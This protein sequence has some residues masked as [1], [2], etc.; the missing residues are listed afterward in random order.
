[1]DLIDACMISEDIA[2]FI[3][4]LRAWAGVE[5]PEQQDKLLAQADLFVAAS[6]SMAA[7]RGCL[8]VGIELLDSMSTV[9]A[10]RIIPGQAPCGFHLPL[11][12]AEVSA[13]ECVLQQLACQSSLG[14]EMTSSILSFTYDGKAHSLELS[15]LPDRCAPE[16]Y[17][18][19]V[20]ARSS[21]R[22][23]ELQ[24]R[25][26]E[27]EEDTAQEIQSLE[28]KL[29]ESV[30]REEA[31]SVAHASSADSS[32][33]PVTAAAASTGHA[34]LLAALREG[35][36]LTRVRRQQPQITSK[37]R[38]GL[39]SSLRQGR[40]LR[41]A[42]RAVASPP[43]AEPVPEPPQTWD[44]EAREL[45]FTGNMELPAQYARMLQMGAPLAAC[46]AI[47]RRH[48][49]NLSEY[50]PPPQ[51]EA[52]AAKAIP[53][54]HPN[55][56]PTAPSNAPWLGG[57]PPPPSSM[58]AQADASATAPISAVKDTAF[59]G[60]KPLPVQ[61]SR[62][63]E[64][65]ASLPAVAAAMRRGGLFPSVYSAPQAA[66]GVHRGS[67]GG[68]ED[69]ASHVQAAPREVPVEAQP[70]AAG[71]SS[72]PPIAYPT[73]TISYTGAQGRGASV[74]SRGAGVQG[75]GARSVQRRAEVHA[76]HQ[77][78]V[79]RDRFTGNQPLPDSLARMVRVGVPP[80][81]VVQRMGYE[82]LDPASFAWPAGQ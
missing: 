32:P 58:F 25:V 69:H 15:A 43:A 80:A 34:G 12:R 45:G 21:G 31:A 54:W 41:T 66:A 67:G 19:T 5:C 23:L 9:V 35:K 29:R 24:G 17:L 4:L 59:T 37:E 57:P 38:S 78:T 27:L 26:R 7:D 40:A 8:L 68:S 39:I 48:S 70:A 63:F 56:P 71:Q 52:R 3:M 79:A 73:T 75:G 72:P 77:D 74:Q 50:A 18:L 6:I 1:M 11:P 82:G 64:M 76:S 60:T 44:E 46:A 55:R 10:V 2:P 14:L 53:G 51:P 20:C 28:C 22:Q 16:L 36:K 81:G 30:V 42:A 49:H 13:L 33:S 47:M 61:Y 65:G 62:L